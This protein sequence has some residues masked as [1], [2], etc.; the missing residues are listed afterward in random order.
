[1]KFILF[2]YLYKTFAKEVNTTKEDLVSH[3]P[4]EEIRTCVLTEFLRSIRNYSSFVCKT[5]SCICVWAHK[6]FQ[7]CLHLRF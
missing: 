1:M 4:H 6:S 5:M 3:T 2:L 7:I